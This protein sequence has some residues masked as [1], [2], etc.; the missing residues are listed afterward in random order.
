MQTPAW[1]RHHHYY[2]Y[3]SQHVFVELRNSGRSTDYPFGFLHVKLNAKSE[4]T[5][6]IMGAAKI[7]FDKKKG[8]YEIESYGN[9]YVKPPTSA[10]GTDRGRPSP[11]IFGSPLL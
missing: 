4:G 5:G 2:C 9:Q 11:P 10:L 6:Q 8:Q 3:R 7:R 1:T